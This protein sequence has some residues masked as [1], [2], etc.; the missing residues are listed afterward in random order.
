MSRCCVPVVGRSC[1]RGK[2][3]ARKCWHWGRR[4]SVVGSRFRERGWLAGAEGGGKRRGRN[5]RSRQAAAAGKGTWRLRRW[6]GSL[7]PGWR[8]RSRGCHGRAPERTAKRA[9][10]GRPGRFPT[11]AKWRTKVRR[12]RWWRWRGLE[13]GAVEGLRGRCCWRCHSAEAK[14]CALRRVGLRDRSSGWGLRL[15]RWRRREGTGPAR[16]GW[17]G[18]WNLDRRT[19]RK[20]IGG[21]ARPGHLGR[22]GHPEGHR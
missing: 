14:W 9:G 8:G 15:F 20:R 10:V 11:G 7:Q 22:L 19:K 4:G 6:R 13:S 16:R 2:G 3:E 17:G 18:R 5:S 1:R 21:L 12:G